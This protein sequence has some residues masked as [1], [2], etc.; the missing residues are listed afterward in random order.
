MA[1]LVAQFVVQGEQVVEPH[2]PAAGLVLAGSVG[3]QAGKLQ[4]HG[5]LV[6]WAW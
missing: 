5:N 1:D 4:G 3:R 6:H 2:A